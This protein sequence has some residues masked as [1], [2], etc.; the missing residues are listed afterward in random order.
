MECG[1]AAHLRPQSPGFFRKGRAVAYSPQGSLF[2]YH[3]L[4]FGDQEPPSPLL[5]R[6]AAHLWSA[7][8]HPD[9]DMG[10]GQPWRG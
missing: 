3:A 5:P 1:R 10:G 4:A 8:F 2:I 9:S 6:C 7:V